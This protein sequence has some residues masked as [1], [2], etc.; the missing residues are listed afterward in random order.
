MPI[1]VWFAVFDMVLGLVLN[2]AATAANT[3]RIDMVLD[4]F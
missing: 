2:R 4:I 1:L 3:L